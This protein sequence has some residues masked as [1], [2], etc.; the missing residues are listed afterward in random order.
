MADHDQKFKQNPFPTKFH[1]PLCSANTINQ[2]FH[3]VTILSPWQSYVDEELRSFQERR[4]LNLDKFAGSGRVSVSFVSFSLIDFSSKLIGH[5]RRPPRFDKNKMV[6]VERIW[7]HRFLS[8]YFYRWW[9]S[10]FRE[11]SSNI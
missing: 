7:V 5:H 8:T 9:G 3:K 4:L 11:N 1:H 6:R 10:L 2:I